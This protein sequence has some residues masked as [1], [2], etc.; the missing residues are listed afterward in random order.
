M[1]LRSIINNL[2]IIKTFEGWLKNLDSYG[3]SV[4]QPTFEEFIPEYDLEI[5]LEKNLHKFQRD[6]QLPR[7]KKIARKIFKFGFILIPIIVDENYKMVDGQHRAIVAYK[8]GFTHI[9]VVVY[10]FKTSTDKA[11]FFSEMS[12]PEGG[13]IAV[14]DRVNAAHQ[15]KYPYESLLYMLAEKDPS[16]SFCDKVSLKGVKNRNKKIPLP[17]FIKMVNWIVFGVRRPWQQSIDAPLQDLAK[18]M[19]KKEYANALARMN[20]FASWLFGWAGSTRDSRPLLYKDKIICGML[21]FYL[22]MEE[23][24]TTKKRLNRFKR[25]SRIRFQTYEL[26]NLMSFDITAVPGNIIKAHNHGR[27]EPQRLKDV[28]LKSVPWA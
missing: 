14:L 6:I 24:A 1:K 2:P 27:N 22:I 28:D 3:G 7:L 18:D 9:P 5:L 12:K 13:A 11:D 17:A 23:N 20:D 15:S 21:D 26:N 4:R 19:G 10:S 8:M 25:D 16:S